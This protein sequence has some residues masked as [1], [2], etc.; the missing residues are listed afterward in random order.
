MCDSSCGKPCTPNGCHDSHPSGRY[1][2]NGPSAYD[3]FG[4]TCEPEFEN[5]DDACAIAEVPAMVEFI[6]IAAMYSPVAEKILKRIG[7]G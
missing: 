6:K 4:E 7:E 3:S 5:K 1:I 2:V